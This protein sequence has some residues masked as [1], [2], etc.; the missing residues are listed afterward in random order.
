MLTF[1]VDKSNEIPVIEVNGEIAIYY[2]DCNLDSNTHTHN[3]IEVVYV[4]KGVGL[5]YIN[6]IPYNVKRGDILFINYGQLHMVS[7]NKQQAEDEEPM[8]ILDILIR[9][10]FID[11]EL[12][13][14][15]NAK[16]MLHFLFLN[17]SR[18]WNSFHPLF[19]SAEKTLLRLN[20]S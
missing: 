19:L 7:R 16:E 18:V 6:G 5:Q 12:I 1:T 10:G 9:P 13:E 3:Y 17:A 20:I 14:S 15:R 11:R 8:R 4:L 2:D